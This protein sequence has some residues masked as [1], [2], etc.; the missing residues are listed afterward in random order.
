MGVLYSRGSVEHD[1]TSLPIGT[2]D[3]ATFSGNRITRNESV[4]V[5]RY[6]IPCILV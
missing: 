4:V 6:S 3:L 5:V 1:Q 2:S